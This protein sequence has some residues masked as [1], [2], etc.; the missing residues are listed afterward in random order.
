MAKLERGPEPGQAVF[1]GIDLAR[2]TW[3]FSAR[4]A[5]REQRRWSTA[6]ELR[7]VEALVSAFGDRVLHVAYEACGFGYEIAWA[8]ERR[9]VAVTVVAPSTIAR[10]PGLRVK[11]DRLDAHALAEHL[12]HG[13]LK[14]IAIPTRADHEHRQLSRLYAQVTQDRKRAQARL[15]AMLQEHGRLGPGPRRGWRAYA[16]WLATQELA[17]S[18]RHCVEELLAARAEAAQRAARVRAALVRVAHE[19]AYAPLVTRLEAQPGFGR[20]TAIRLRLEVGDLRRFGRAAAFAHDL[21]LTPSEYSSGARV[22]RG[23]LTKHGPGAVRSWLVQCAW[24]SIR[25]T[26]GDPAL[27]ATF[28]RLC[29]RIGKKRAIIAVTRRLALRVRARWLAADPAPA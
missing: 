18:V 28:E 8:L 5:G 12:E 14:R 10:A 19:A 16:T 11:T 29:P 21:G 26:C 22:E 15:R 2:T 7:H 17:R 20:F 27:R 3:T 6:S 9:G 23:H 24:V 13:R 4:W 25:P 1:V